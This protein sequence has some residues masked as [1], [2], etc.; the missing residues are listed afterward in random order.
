MLLWPERAPQLEHPAV[1]RFV[2]F[3]ALGHQA[4]LTQLELNVPAQQ[5]LPPILQGTDI[6]SNDLPVAVKPP[7]AVKLGVADNPA[8]RPL[9]TALAVRAG[10]AVPARQV[11][12]EP[13]QAKRA[14]PYVDFR[15]AGEDGLSGTIGSLPRVPEAV[16]ERPVVD[17]RSASRTLEGLIGLAA[18]CRAKVP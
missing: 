14:R 2:E 6:R 13:R 9:S 4:P 8:A 3:G 17:P 16:K 10:E 5:L 7:A 18:P 12:T 1:E 15:F 11:I